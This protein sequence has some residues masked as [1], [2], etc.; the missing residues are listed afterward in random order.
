MREVNKNKNKERERERVEKASRFPVC[1]LWGISPVKGSIAHGLKSQWEAVS[2]CHNVLS[3]H[4]LRPYLS[5]MPGATCHVR[6]RQSH[7]SRLHFNLLLT[8]SFFL[9][10]NLLFRISSHV[11]F[12]TGWMIV[13]RIWWPYLMDS[14]EIK[15]PFLNKILP[16]FINITFIWIVH[17]FLCDL[18]SFSDGGCTKLHVLIKPI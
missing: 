14:S 12:D 1:K 2:N 5:T 13:F 11:L 4:L 10:I 6:A 16:Y 15:A 3:G 8:S 9:K 18:P 7:R 17:C